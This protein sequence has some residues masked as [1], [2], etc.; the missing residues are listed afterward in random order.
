MP[1]YKL[2]LTAYPKQEQTWLMPLWNNV[3][4]LKFY[5][6]RIIWYKILFCLAYSPPPH[7]HFLILNWLEKTFES[8]LNYK[9]KPINPKGSQPWVFIGR[10]DTEAEAPIFFPPN[11]KSWLIGKDPDTGKDWRQKEKR[12]AE[13]EMVRQHHQL[14]GQDLEQT[15]GDSG[16]QESL[17]HWS[18]WGH[19]EPD[20]T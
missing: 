1:L 19:K 12:L 2:F 20:M 8:R 6:S 5:I 10:T 17:V 3:Y 9:I 4:F 15:P 16:G 13:D 18:P 11:V 7:T 14:N